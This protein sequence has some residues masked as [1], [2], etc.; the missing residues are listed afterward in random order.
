MS[1]SNKP[2]ILFWIIGIIALLWNAMGCL[3]Y[4][5][6][7]YGMEMATAELSTEQIAFMEALPAWNTGLFAI[8]VFSGLAASI[9]FLMRKKLGVNLFLISFVIA[10]IMQIY[11]IFGSD[12]PEV[13]ADRQPYLMPVIIV[14]LGLIF[15]WYSKKEKAA[16]TLS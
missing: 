13:F 10:A 8:A 7:A 15:V 2:G 9:A 12:A 5:A 4:I 11:W 16:G 6:Q 3:N 1:N 14:V